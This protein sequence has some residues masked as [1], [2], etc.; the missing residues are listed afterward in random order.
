MTFDKVQVH[1]RIRIRLYYLEFRIR[2]LH[3]ISD[4]ADPDPQHCHK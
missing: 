3:K 4:F 2:I 1:L